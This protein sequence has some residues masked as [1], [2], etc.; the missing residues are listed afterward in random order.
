MD[1]TVNVMLD[2]GAFMPDKAH[3]LDAGFDLRTPERIIVGKDSAAE[4]D[5][6]VHLEI[7]EGYVGMIKSKSGL[8]HKHGINTEGVIDAGFTGSIKVKIYN[9]SGTHIIFE[10]G[11]KITQIVFLEIP[12][13]KLQLTNKFGEYER[14]DNG[15]GSSGRF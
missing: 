11:E 15:Y 5:T 6:G 8:N 1:I 10:K 13:T 9:H 12:N 7:P 14:G 4:V 2:E 3:D